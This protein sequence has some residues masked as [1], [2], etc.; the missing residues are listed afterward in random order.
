MDRAFQRKPDG[1][2]D[3]LLSKAET[4]TGSSYGEL[5]SEKKSINDSTLAR[6]AGNILAGFAGNPELNRETATDAVL[7]RTS[8]GL[9]RAIV[10]EIERS[11]PTE[12]SA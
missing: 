1:L 12:K 6:I 8:V 11:A 10:A 5:M 9:A 3:F 2:Q 7:V 4:F